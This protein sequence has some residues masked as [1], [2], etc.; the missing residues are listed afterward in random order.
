MHNYG[1]ITLCT[2]DAIKG[3]FCATLE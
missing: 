1:I 3:T 2:N